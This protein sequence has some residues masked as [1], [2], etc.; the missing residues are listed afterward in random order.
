M[1]EQLKYARDL[2]YDLLNDFGRVFVVIRHSELSDMGSRGF[3]EEEKESGLVLVFTAKNHRDMKWEDSG[4]FVTL[5]FGADNRL[6]KC[7]I[8]GDD[9]LAVFS[10]DARIKFERWDTAPENEEE[11]APPS[12]FERGESPKEDGLPKQDGPK[13]DGPPKE[14][15]PRDKPTGGGGKKGGSSKK[16]K[17][18]KLV[19]LDQFRKKKEK[20]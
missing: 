17:G 14:D 10:P 11:Q 18:G 9:L 13:Q 1:K 5:G 15:G 6:D 20:K 12:V 16:G 4:V 2:F 19:S 8:H 3:T 7:F